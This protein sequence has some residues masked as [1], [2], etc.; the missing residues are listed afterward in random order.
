MLRVLAT[1]IPAV[2]PVSQAGTVKSDV[3]WKAFL[4]K[5][6]IVWEQLPQKFDHGSFHGNGMLGCTIYQNTPNR[7][8]WEMGR[9]DVTAHRRDNNRLPIGGLVL[10]TN[11]RITGGN[12]R[13]SLWDA[14]TRGLVETDKG[15]IRF[16]TYIHTDEMVMIVDLECLGGELGAA[17]EWLA[18]PAVDQ[19]NKKQFKDDPPNPPFTEK[20]VGES[21]L[22][23]QGRIAGG[24]YATAWESRNLGQSKQ[25]IYLSITDSFPG[26]AAES[27]VLENLKRARAV[28]DAEL[29][30][31]HTA[32]WHDYYPKSFVSVP[33]PMVEGFYWVQMYKLGS[34][35]RK[36]RIVM[37]LLGPWFRDT[38]WPRIWWNLN[39][40]ICYLPS[41]A[42]N[43]LEQAGTLVDMLDEN[44]ENFRK[45]AKEIYGIKNGATV[46][47]TTCY[48]GLRGDGSRA[49]DYYVNPGD[50]TWA[51]HNY[52]LHYRYSMDETL[53]K[54]HEKHAFYPLLKE[55]VNVYL[56]LLEEG[57]DGK[58]H[59]PVMHAPE[60]GSAPDN[61][62]NLSLLRWA[63]Q[64]LVS[65]NERYGFNDESLP[66]WKNVLTN[67]V[68]Y[69]VDRNGFMVG[70]G[71][72]YENPTGT[73]HTCSWP[74][75][76]AHWTWS[77]KRMW[78]C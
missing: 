7:L 34:A 18:T 30:K 72:P 66:A 65:L 37:D 4:G 68:S 33:D 51:L 29:W 48:E 74:T 57:D 76:W 15:E 55:S 41:Y 70:A 12:M 6:D 1:V 10:K 59:L 69:Q 26:E 61:N 73:G 71:V 22:C 63:C 23:V 17:V 24:A 39:L 32:W 44:R 47:H 16:Q 42:S 46:P 25:R 38:I 9:S 62:Y 58:L 53:V 40:Q 19:I 28:G 31:S 27:E 3:D 54:D 20:K 21:S 56:H 8:R 75:L 78:I 52:Y 2:L 49:P 35:C 64:T 14:V 67:L 50:F 45:N 11:G 77:S 5:H 13:L 43:H 36:D 60:Y